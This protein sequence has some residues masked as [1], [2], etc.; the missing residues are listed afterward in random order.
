MRDFEAFA[1]V[2]M[3][4]AV[5]QV[6]MKCNVIEIY[7]RHRK[8]K[9]RRPSLLSWLYRWHVMS[10]RGYS[11]YQDVWLHVPED[12]VLHTEM[13]TNP[14]IKNFL[15]YVLLYVT[16]LQ[17]H[18]TDFVYLFLQNYQ[19]SYLYCFTVHFHISISFY[20]QFTTRYGTIH[21]RN[22]DLLLH[23]QP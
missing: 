16:F 7:G 4:G 13:L 18:M 21:T 5:S 20:Q 17:T 15:F 1:C 2:S 11:F 22:T 14:K 10:K 8:K 3:E 6:V 23:H 12:G 9:L 19:H